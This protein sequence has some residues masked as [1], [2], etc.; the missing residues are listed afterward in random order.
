MIF[1][2]IEQ[3]TFDQQD[4]EFSSVYG[5]SVGNLSRELAPLRTLKAPGYAWGSPTI[6]SDRITRRVPPLLL[7]PYKDISIL[8]Y[9]K[10]FK[11]QIL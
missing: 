11:K 6:A 2:W 3:H 1:Y 9:V 8:Y 5:S 10:N 4:E 7:F